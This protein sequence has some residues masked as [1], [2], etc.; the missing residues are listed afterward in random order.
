MICVYAYVYEHVYVI[1][2]CADSICIVIKYNSY[3]LL[4]HGHFSW[5]ERLW[6]TWWHNQDLYIYIYIHIH[7]STSEVPAP[8]LPGVIMNSKIYCVGKCLFYMGFPCFSNVFGVSEDVNSSF[9]D[10][11]ARGHF[12]KMSVDDKNQFNKMCCCL[13]ME[14]A[15]SVEGLSILSSVRT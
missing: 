11:G 1:C 15:N 9:V 5:Q 10:H 6:F 3:I 13:K 2:I 4:P 14:E 7:I 8:R 12:W